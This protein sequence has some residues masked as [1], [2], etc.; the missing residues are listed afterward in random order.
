[1][2]GGRHGGEMLAVTGG[3]DGRDGGT[4]RLDRM[5]RRWSSSSSLWI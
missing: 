1:V 5:R 2:R 4:A 3:D